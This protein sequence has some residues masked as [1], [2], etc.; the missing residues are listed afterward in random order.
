MLK[1]HPDRVITEAV[2]GMIPHNKL[3]RQIMG[4]LKVYAG[5]EHPHEAQLGK[6]D[7]GE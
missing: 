5:D 1:T 2:K 6:S 4:R 3:G 7:K